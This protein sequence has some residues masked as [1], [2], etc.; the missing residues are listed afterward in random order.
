MRNYEGVLLMDPGLDEEGVNEA[1]KLVEKVI[2]DAN[3]EIGNWE[4]WG[5]RRLA[6]KIEGKTEAI[7]VLLTFTGAENT[8]QDL[9]KT[10]E[11]SENILRHMFLRKG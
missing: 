1:S 11:L 5:R 4:R 9:T 8:V 3:G 6:Y 10:C 2:T 7:Y